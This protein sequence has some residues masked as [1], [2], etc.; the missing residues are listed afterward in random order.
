VKLLL[1]DLWGTVFYP[2][3][4]MEE[5]W[6]QRAG[7]LQRELSRLGYAYSLGDVYSACKRGRSLVDRIRRATLREVTVEGEVAAILHLLGVEE[8]PTRTMVEGYLA[9]YVDYAVKAPHVE[10]LLQGARDNGYTVSVASNTMSW[11]HAVR[12]LKRLGLLGLFDAHF[13]SDVVGWRKPS[14]S[15]YRHVLAT[16]RA[17]PEETVIIGDEEA[18]IAAGK[19]GVKTIL[20]E[21]FHSYEGSLKPSARVKDHLE[22][23]RFLEGLRL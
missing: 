17:E 13:Y 2:N 19:L 12:V 21:G 23:L 4:S 9:P 3:I 15:F 6:R 1:V 5:F 20:Y 11:R 18:D 7:V 8:G 14:T 16:L 22:A 10:Q